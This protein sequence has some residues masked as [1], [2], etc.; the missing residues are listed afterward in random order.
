MPRKQEKNTNTVEIP[1]VAKFNATDEVNFFLNSAKIK[2][3]RERQVLSERFGVDGLKPKT[4]EEIGK[5]LGITRERV[6]QIEKNAIG[7]LRDFGK[8]DMR[9]QEIYIIIKDIII[10]NGGIIVSGDL[11]K[12]IFTAVVT[13]KQRYQLSFLISC[14]NNIS[15]LSDADNFK[16]SYFVEPITIPLIKTISAAAISILEKEQNPIEEVKLIREIKMT[17]PEA[18]TDT[19]NIIA[20]LST[21]KEI[22]KTEAGHFGLTK[23]REINPKS[24]KDKTYYILKKHKKPLHYSEISK[25]IQDVGTK[26]KTVTRQAVHNELI[27]D[28]RFILIGRG[29][30]ALKEW[31]Y[32][33]GVVE[34]VIAEILITSGEPMHKDDIIIE[35]LKRRVV[36]ETTILLNLQRDRFRRISR[37]T[38]TISNGRE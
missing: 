37:A 1:S 4:L 19:K 22:I 18:N 26:K 28:D 16:K 33:S 21:A 24:I 6:R 8:T 15:T 32:T 30:Y 27:R 38:Y 23:W 36:K 5:S 12:D 14:S 7:K 34:D 9:A 20:I 11:E 2:K 31:G 13:T 10:N 25:K 3:D 29:I 17:I 35:V